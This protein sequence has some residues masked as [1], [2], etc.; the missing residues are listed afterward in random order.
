LLKS[1]K[2]DM[3]KLA[4]AL[5]SHPADVPALLIWGDRDP[6]VPAFTAKELMRHLADSEQVTLPGVG[7][8]P[9]DERPDQCAELIR[10][11]LIARETHRNDPTRIALNAADHR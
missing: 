10:T 9:N 2:R 7:H 3:K 1:W 8:L 4:E 11:W 6:V 5:A